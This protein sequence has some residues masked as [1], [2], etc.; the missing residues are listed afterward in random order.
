MNNRRLYVH[1]INQGINDRFRNVIAEKDVKAE[2]CCW[3]ITLLTSEEPLDKYDVVIGLPI[4]QT[5]EEL[6]RYTFNYIVKGT[7]ETWF[8]RE[9]NLLLE[10]EEM[11]QH[12]KNRLYQS[13]ERYTND[14][15]KNCYNSDE[16]WSYT[17]GSGN[18]YNGDMAADAHWVFCLEHYIV[19]CYDDENN[20][21]E[22]IFEP[23]IDNHGFEIY[24]EVMA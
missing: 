19:D 22:E 18:A 16:F 10:N 14:V 11:L 7:G 17:L 5:E 12:F 24:K 1:C 4:E 21:W 23:I 6:T 13:V 9:L 8:V 20:R 3:N 2:H 15:L